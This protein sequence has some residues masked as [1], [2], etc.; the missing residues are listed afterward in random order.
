MYLSILIRVHVVHHSTLGFRHLTLCFSHVGY[1]LYLV[2]YI[3]YILYGFS[4]KVS[5]PYNVLWQT[6]QF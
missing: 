2:G 6:S 3:L 1:I 4:V 5:I